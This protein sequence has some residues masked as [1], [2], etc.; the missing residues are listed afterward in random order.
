VGGPRHQIALIEDTEA[1]VFLVREAL[2]QAGLEFD[3]LVLQDGEKAVEFIAAIETGQAA[4]CPH[5]IILDLNL[6]MVSGQEILERVRQTSKCSLVPVIILTSSESPRDRAEVLRL[7]ATEY[8]QKSS[9]LD[10]FMKLGALARKLIE[11]QSAASQ[12]SGS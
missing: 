2:E 9:R 6:P 8:F 1:D 12:A 11:S 4:S 3:L 7:G 5:L 10:E